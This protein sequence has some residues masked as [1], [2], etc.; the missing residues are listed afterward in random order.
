MQHQHP[1]PQLHMRRD[2]IQRQHQPD[3]GHHPAHQL[4]HPLPPPSLRHSRSEAQLRPRSN[5]HEA[6]HPPPP[7][8]S[9]SS[10]NP[11]PPYPVRRSRSS[12]D[13][14]AQSLSSP[15]PPPPPPLSRLKTALEEAHFLA[16]GLVSRPA[17]STKHH[18][19][20]RHSHGLVWYKGPQTSIAITILSDEPLPDSRTIH[21]QEKGYSGSMGMSLRALIGPRDD[22]IDV[23]PAT[24]VQA[25]HIPVVE[26]RAVQRDLKRFASKASGRLQGHVPRET[27][28]IRIPVSATDG[29]FRLVLCA[30]RVGSDNAD[31]AVVRRRILC[32]SPVFRIASTSTN[33]SVVR[34]ASL[35]T[36]P[37]EM[38]VKVAST[39][40]T[41][42]IKKYTG[43]AGA[44]VHSSAGKF[45]ARHSGKKAV[46]VATATVSRGKAYVGSSGLRNAVQQSWQHNREL[47]QGSQHDC[48]RQETSLLPTVVVDVIG[49]DHGPEKPFP[50]EF[51]GRVSPRLSHSMVAELDL[52]AA[53]L[54]RVPD[55][56]TARLGGVFMAWASIIMPPAKSGP[57]IPP[58]HHGNN[59]NSK[60]NNNSNE[61]APAIVTIAPATRDDAHPTI[62][63]SNTVRVQIAAEI[64]DTFAPGRHVEVLLMGYLRP[65]TAPASTTTN[66]HHLCAQHAHDLSVTLN[67]LS[68]EN[69]CPYETMARIEAVKRARS[70]GDR[71]D[72]ATGRVQRTINRLPLHWAGVRCDEAVARDALVGKGGLWVRR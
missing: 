57:H 18:T 58:S 47:Q 17:E 68:R 11:T 65:A 7:S 12:C 60:N 64:N 16:A 10:S 8:T 48:V 71:L 63:M 62:N 38:G 25:R 70:L 56:I 19:I 26:E 43:I 55:H 5:L 20:I 45:A 35:S 50:I 44:V 30:G 72:D 29:Y 34:G 32:G 46:V 52:P 61:W 37:L 36:M 3:G 33:M 6:P 13:L 14:A 15:P 4:Q 54:D 28:L 67:S 2:H 21:L 53:N 59:S 24:E 22:W 51:D 1:P 40:G 9:F 23:T 31:D 27:H 42:V 69:W 66:T 49:A 39:V 41:Q